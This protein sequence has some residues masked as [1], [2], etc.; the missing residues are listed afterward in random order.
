MIGIL[1]AKSGRSR[2][3]SAREARQYDAGKRLL[4]F[5]KT[6]EAFGLYGIQQTFRR[7]AVHSRLRDNVAAVNSDHRGK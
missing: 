1:E 6:D 7:T 4:S 5:I 3:N 2:R